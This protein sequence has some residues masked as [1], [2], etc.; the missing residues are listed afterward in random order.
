MCLNFQSVKVS[1]DNEISLKV[2]N[3]LN[4]YIIEYT[5]VCAC[6]LQLDSGLS[7]LKETVKLSVKYPELGE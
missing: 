3:L 4:Y 5:S 1:L 2:L 7:E 6:N